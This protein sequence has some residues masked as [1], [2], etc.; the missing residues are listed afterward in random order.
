LATAIVSKPGRPRLQVVPENLTRWSDEELMLAYRDGM[1]P[2]FDVLVR[3]YRSPLLSFLV[4]MTRNVQLA[5]EAMMEAFLKLHRSAARY[6]PRAKFRTYLYT[7]AYRQALTE[8]GRKG[9]KLKTVP[10]QLDTPSG[11]VQREFAD[12]QSMR[13]EQ[14]LLLGEQVTRLNKELNDLP[15][16]HRAAFVLYYADG[17]SCQECADILGLTRAEVK[18]RLAYARR[19]LRARLPDL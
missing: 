3:R 11:T 4:R 5:E 7:I 18:G 10:D 12:P 9:N 19:L 14:A 13:A 6:E 16:A 1:A 17:L 15:E 2:A 8:M